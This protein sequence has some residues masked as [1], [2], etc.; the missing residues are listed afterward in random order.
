ML[1]SPVPRH[2]DMETVLVVLI[3]LLITV[4]VI[5]AALLVLISSLRNSRSKE[6]N[7]LSAERSLST[8]VGNPSTETLRD[9]VLD[10]MRKKKLLSSSR[11]SLSRHRS[12]P[13]IITVHCSGGEGNAA[14]VASKE[15]EEVV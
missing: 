15:A 8:E 6:S 3:A 12:S 4:P 5:V 1:F 13:D 7:S 2:Q 14:A 11:S 9:V 10:S